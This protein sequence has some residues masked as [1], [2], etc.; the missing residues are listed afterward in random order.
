MDSFSCEQSFFDI[1]RSFERESA[2]TVGMCCRVPI[3]ATLGLE[4]L[5][6]IRCEN[7]T[8]S[9]MLTYIFLIKT[10]M[11]TF[12]EA[13]CK[14]RLSIRVYLSGQRVWVIVAIE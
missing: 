8:F 11:T 10:L 4:T 7:D 13:K 5:R 14:H 2:H 1:L 6:N 12:G 9:E 3:L